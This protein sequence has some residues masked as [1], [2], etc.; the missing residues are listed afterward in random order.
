MLQLPL[1]HD[2][3]S[4]I[5]LADWLELYAL[6]SAGSS[7]SEGDLERALQRSGQYGSQRI[8]ALCAE[9]A[10]ELG[11]RAIAARRAYPFS[12]HEGV[13]SLRGSKED[14]ISYVF[15]LCLSYFGDKQKKG[16]RI[17]PRRLFEDL[18]AHAA[19]SFLSGGSYRFAAPRKDV[20]SFRGALEKLCLRMGEGTGCKQQDT[21]SA[22]D[23]NLDIVAWRHFPDR[24]PG[25]LLLFGQCATGDDWQEPKLTSLQPDD[26]CKYWLSDYPASPLI[27]AYFIP[28]RVDGSDWYKVNV[29]GGIVFDR[30]RISY[31]VHSGKKLK[32]TQD[33]VAW[34]EEVLHASN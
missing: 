27:K 29:F 6:I 5:K 10:S 21:R 32:V 17:F 18:A 15:C 30:C 22:Q 19:K 11:P 8:D 25:K 4:P 24:L 14:F 31:W 1:P 12:L 7:S 3:D 26:F 20:P 34:V 23:D 33:Y 9:V 2:S 28:H 13:V 16:D